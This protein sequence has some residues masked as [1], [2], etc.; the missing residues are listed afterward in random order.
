[1]IVV[2][3]REFLM[4]HVGIPYV[5]GGDDPIRGFDCSGFVQEFLLSFGA[6]PK[7]GTD[8][9]AQGLYN[10]IMKK[11]RYG[12]KALGSLAFY[13]K[14]FQKVTHVAI[15]LSPHFIFEFGGGGSATLTKEDAI[16]Q[17]AFGRIRP[18]EN[19]TDLI[20]CVMPQYPYP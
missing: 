6:H 14:S 12:E 11:G 5:W 8:L 7:P 20:A 4:N 13:G 18:L 3:M 19:R 10:E 9:N 1:M 17:N 15:M 2:L 16:A